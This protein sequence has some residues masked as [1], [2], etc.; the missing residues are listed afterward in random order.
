LVD[1]LK[2]WVHE[3]KV[4]RDESEGPIGITAV[5]TS[6]AGMEMLKGY[7][8]TTTT[9]TGGSL[10][11]STSARPPGGDMVL[12]HAHNSLTVDHGGQGG[13]SSSAGWIVLVLFLLVL[14]MCSAIFVFDAKSRRKFKKLGRRGISAWRSHSFKSEDEEDPSEAQEGDED[15][16][17]V[18]AND[19]DCGKPLMNRQKYRESPPGP[20]PTFGGMDLVTV[21]PQ[22]LQV[23]PL[24]A[25]LPP[26]GVPIMEPKRSSQGSQSRRPSGASLQQQV[27]QEGM[28]L[29]QITANGL[30]VTPWQGAPPP[31]VPMMD[32]F[33][34][35]QP[36]MTGMAPG[37]TMV[38][39]RPMQYPM[40]MMPPSMH[41]GQVGT[42]MAVAPP[43]S[44]EYDL[45]TVTPTGL[46]VSS[47]DGN[48]T[49]NGLPVLDP[50]RPPQPIGTMPSMPSLQM[51][52][53]ATAALPT[54]TF[55]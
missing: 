46:Q 13:S 30:S 12:S 35:M 48:R 18:S 4:A 2:A 3:A 32:R 37:T 55:R 22:G 47:L 38:D 45:V 49:P 51:Q 39:G 26:P 11:S 9:T 16:G 15:E 21:T 1:C 25:D 17:Q 33:G 53:Y 50:A 7:A 52:N 54:T 31:G 5:Y 36:G 42:Q 28:D 40:G 8:P 29:V 34:M 10:T 20:I 6:I 23:T 19:I 43:P 14:L 24:G 41:G 44:D 27:P